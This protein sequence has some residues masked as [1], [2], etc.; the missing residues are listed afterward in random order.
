MEGVMQGKNLFK[1]ITRAH[2]PNDEPIIHLSSYK[3]GGYL[4]IRAGVEN[5]PHPQCILLSQ[6]I[7]L[8]DSEQLGCKFLKVLFRRLS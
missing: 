6:M 5:I 3:F 1:K 8:H 7:L 4:E 2:G